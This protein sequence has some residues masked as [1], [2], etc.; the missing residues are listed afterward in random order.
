M[1]EW[2]DAQGG[3]AARH[4]Y[5][6]FS[7]INSRLVE[8]RDYLE[9]PQQGLTTQPVQLNLPAAQPQAGPPSDEVM[10]S[11]LVNTINNLAEDDRNLENI[12]TGMLANNTVMGQY[13][14]DHPSPQLH[15]Q[16]DQLNELVEMWEEGLSMGENID[17]LKDDIMATLHEITVELGNPLADV[18]HLAAPQLQPGERPGMIIPEPN[19]THWAIRITPEMKKRYYK[20]KKKTGA[21]FSRM[22]P[23][24]GL[25]AAELYNQMQ[26]E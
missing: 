14:R 10:Q 22:L 19:K 21:G 25:G 12:L 20:L 9:E 3:Q 5:Y 11:Y 2:A 13:L 17:S 7:E 4:P 6:V 16:L 24:L 18:R 26:E 23:P 8:L 1:D 15:R